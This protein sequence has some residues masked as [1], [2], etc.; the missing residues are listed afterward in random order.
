MADSFSTFP[1]GKCEALAMLYVQ[2]Q[3]LSSLTPEQLLDMYEDAY[4][5]LREHNRAKR[6]ERKD[7]K[8]TL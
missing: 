7:N 3:D 6:N 1:A 5:R 4:A 2:S 8:W